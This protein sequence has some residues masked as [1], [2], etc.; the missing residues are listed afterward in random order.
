MALPTPFIPWGKAART[1]SKCLSKRNF[2]KLVIA[3]RLSSTH[4]RGK[5]MRLEKELR[6]AIIGGTLL[7][8]YSYMSSCLSSDTIKGIKQYGGP[9]RSLSTSSDGKGS[10]SP[11]TMSLLTDY[12]VNT[13]LR[14]LEESY[15]VNRG[16]GVLRYDVS[17][18]PS[19]NPM[20]DT[21]VEQIITV[22]NEQTQAQEELY[23]FGIFDGHG[24]PYTSSKLSEALVPY[25]A[26]QLSMIYAQGNEAL[27]SEAIDD[28]I[29]QG[30][31]QLDND[32]V[33]KTLGHF[34]ENPSKES[35]IEALPAVSGACSLLAMYD[36]NNCTLKV[37][38]A[39]DSRA[40]LGRV[41]ENGQ[42]TV[43]SLTID[44]TGDNMDEVAR[45]REEH[46]DEPNCVRNGRILG[47]LQPSRAFGDYRY[48]VKEIN[49]KN[50]YDLPSHL[51]IFFRKEPRDFLT[52]P[53]VTARPAITTAQIDSS[54]RFMV[55][56]SDGLFELLTNEEI[57]GLVVK[58]MEKH[59]VKK[60][61]ETLKA[62]RDKIPAVLDTTV[63]AENQRPAF[64]YKDAKASSGYLME[65]NNVATHLIRNALSGGG[66]K[67]YVST[68]ISIP[69]PKSRS[70]RDDLTVTV[71]FFGE[72]Q[73]QPDNQLILN[74]EATK[75]LE[76][77][78]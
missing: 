18:L 75:P 21:R 7:L 78:L 42:W 64:R 10:G 57:A 69:S 71:V 74:H 36:S 33:Q 31:L 62:T 56:G 37:A 44:Q 35:L 12:E 29:E 68:L 14:S 34:F 22:P 4:Q 19:N 17:Q 40:L 5:P 38:L 15:Y 46:P 8:T 65:D 45:I 11:D 23:F 1:L 70:Y 25:V 16:K 66:D 60:G 26:H 50:V 43:Q 55:I 49:G 41:D 32:I 2:S 59:P 76:P 51:K 39:G 24:G 6:Y 73:G 61:F 72:E 54:A 58:W 52:P 20:E 3:R 48:K 67:R 28:A 30:F 13:K 63:H 27:T 9:A 47:S 77:K 53:Y